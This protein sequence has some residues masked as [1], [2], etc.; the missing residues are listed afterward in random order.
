MKQKLLAQQFLQNHADNDNLYNF[1]NI[2]EPEYKKTFILLNLLQD[3]DRFK[4]FIINQYRP[5]QSNQ[6]GVMD[7]NNFKVYF[8]N[9]LQRVSQ[10][11]DEVRSVFINSG[12]TTVKI[13][14]R[15]C[16]IL[17]GHTIET[18]NFE[19]ISDYTS[20]SSSCSY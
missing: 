10:I 8:T 16:V 12:F 4:D 5:A 20:S 7:F 14:L 3:K 15:F 18:N 2:Y 1:P 19:L 13:Q 6:H 9:T 17:E 11:I